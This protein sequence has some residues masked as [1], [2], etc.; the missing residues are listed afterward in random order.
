MK[1]AVI[2]SVGILLALPAMGH[3]LTPR[4]KQLKDK[5][6]QLARKNTNNIDNRPEVRAKIDQ[7]IQKLT[8]DLPPVD[9][10]AW[11]QDAV[12]SWK[13]LWA[14]EQ[15]NGSPEI[16][17][18]LDR[19]YQ[20]VAPTGF[21]VN[22][23]ERIMPNGERVTFALRAQ[24][25]VS[26]N[27]QTTRILSGYFKS[28]PLLSGMSIPYLANDILSNSFEIFTPMQLGEFPNGPI[29][30]EGDLTISFLDED[31][32]VGTAPNVYTGVSEM[33]VMVRERIIP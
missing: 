13:Q 2:L 22:L 5:I 19:I 3:D 15:N 6:I 16:K 18:N 1:L 31:L 4:Q 24:G 21:A 8:K 25:T 9:E 27:V 14:D 30:A 33:F 7:L 10:K 11:K 12:G 32:K 28:T 29:N 17:Q 20:Y 26:G 23:G